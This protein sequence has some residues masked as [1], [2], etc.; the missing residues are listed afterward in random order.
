MSG[1]VSVR[2]GVLVVLPTSSAIFGKVVLSGSEQTWMTV[3]NTARESA[4]IESPHGLAP[5]EAVS[6]GRC[7]CSQRNPPVRDGVPS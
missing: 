3:L 2:K 5:T 7:S 1:R 4:T 6:S